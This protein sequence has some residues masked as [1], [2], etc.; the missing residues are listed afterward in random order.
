MNKFLEYLQFALVTAL[1]ALALACLAEP[2]LQSLLPST[3]QPKCNPVNT[4][5]VLALDNSGSMG[6][7]GGKKLTDLQIAVNTLIQETNFDDSSCGSKKMAI[8]TFNVNAEELVSLTNDK[9]Q[10]TNAVN[11]IQAIGGTRIEKG[12][13]KAKESLKE[14]NGENSIVLF[15]DAEYEKSDP[16]K[17]KEAVT[18]VKESG[19]GLRAIV[20]ANEGPDFINLKN[21][22][23]GNVIRTDDNNIGETVSEELKKALGP[24]GIPISRRASLLYAGL[25]T[26]FIT[27]G[28]AIALIIFQNIYYKRKRILSKKEGI[29]C[30]LSLLLGF[31]IGVLT[32]LIVNSSSNL[33]P[34]YISQILAWALLGMFL[35][36]GAAVLQIFPNLH[37]FKSL[38]FGFAGGLVAGIIYYYAQKGFD[39]P[40]IGRW[41][42]A[43]ALGTAI[44]FL[45]NLM[46]NRGIENPIWL[47]VFYISDKVSRYHPLGKVPVTIGSSPE[48]TVYMDSAPPIALRFWLKGIKIKAENVV[49][50]RI[51]DY[52]E[53]ELAKIRPIELQ[54]TMILSI[55]DNKDAK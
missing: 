55:V 35:T 42:G 28:I 44:G 47:R 37:L 20:T 54:P 51:T 10:L 52:K 17:I 14:V 21:L 27:F 6:E 34:E 32:L 53:S 11:S 41:L 19:I 31:L 13:E 24:F 38:G 40:F 22:F 7:N 43:V 45:I 12:L 8:V 16:T 33:M 1:G 3:S 36:F 46:V 39:K 49:A 5:T 18:D 26:S 15:T 30:I 4:N 29:A 9:N 48:A 23:S 2:L 25:W 50:E